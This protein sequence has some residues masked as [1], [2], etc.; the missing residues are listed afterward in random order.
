MS[1]WAVSWAYNQRPKRSGEKF[2]LVTLAQ[3]A[4]ARGYCFPGQGKLARLTEMGERTVRG[5]L[6]ELERQG[7]VRSEERRRE[8]GT[9]TSNG[10]WL[11]G[12]PEAFVASSDQPAESAGSQPAAESAGSAG[13]GMSDSSYRQ[14]SPPAESAGHEY[15]ALEVE[16]STEKN[17]STSPPATQAAKKA[18]KA[19]EPRPDVDGLCLLLAE[20]IIG[21]GANPKTY[22]RKATTKAW[23][24]PMRLLLDEDLA[25]D[26]HGQPVP[27]PTRIEKARKAINWCQDSVFWRK[28]VLCPD[29]LR[30]KYDQLRLAAQEEQQS[31][32]HRNGNGQPARR[33]L[34]QM[35]I[36]SLPPTDPAEMEA[37]YDRLLEQRTQAQGAPP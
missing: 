25:V 14:I 18:K 23:R 36:A 29:K 20:R 5:H 12:P 2:T 37:Y 13:Q 3:F 15:K 30:E 33:E 4:D 11:L 31:N 7:L 10:Y 8:D 1:A 21:N 34:P 27:P 6:D 35:D 22:R 17:L 26:Q 19:E 32:G 24:N 28:N 16:S 9:R